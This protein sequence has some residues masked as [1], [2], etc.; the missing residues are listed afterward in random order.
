M[1]NKNR[2]DLTE[3]ELVILTAMCLGLSKKEIAQQCRIAEEIVSTI[4]TSILDKI[5]LSKRAELITFAKTELIGELDRHLRSRLAQE[6]HDNVQSLFAAAMHV[7]VLRRQAV[8]QSNPLANA[9][10]R[11]Q[12]LLIEQARK[13]RE[14]MRPQLDV[15]ASTFLQFLRDLPERFERETGISTRFVSEL[16]EV[17]MSQQV[18]WE[19]ARIVQEGLINVRRLTGTQDVLLKLTATD[20]HWQL[21]IEGD[22]PVGRDNST[23]LRERAALIGGEVWVESSPSGGWRCVVTVPKTNQNRKE[24]C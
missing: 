10:G 17:Q 24:E 14:L 3:R 2:F 12:D 4:L 1:D 9:L 23:V 16:D 8:A 21:T 22:R 5:G 19:L 15:D 11:L 20:S 13:L 18:C 7:D 6:L